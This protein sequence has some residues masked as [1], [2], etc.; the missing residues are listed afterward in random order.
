VTAARERLSQVENDP[1]VNPEVVRVQPVA[2]A[3]S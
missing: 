1:A 3:G 2:V